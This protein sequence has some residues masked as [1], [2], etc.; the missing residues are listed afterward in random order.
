MAQEHYR[1]LIREL[2]ITERQVLGLRDERTFHV[3]GVPKDWGTCEQGGCFA[4]AM[5]VSRAAIESQCGK[6]TLTRGAHKHE[7]DVA[8]LMVEAKR[9]RG[10]KFSVP[11][12]PPAYLATMKHQALGNFVERKGL[13][14]PV[15]ASITPHAVSSDPGGTKELSHV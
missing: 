4:V 7:F 9:Q 2:A 5:Y 12:R 10:G 3:E 8:T 6:I 13:I 1:N 15:S 14:I 11:K